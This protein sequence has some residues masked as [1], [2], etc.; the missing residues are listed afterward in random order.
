MDS[1]SD[2][3]K[4][5]Q[6]TADLRV[7]PASQQRGREQ[8][9]KQLMSLLGI[10]AA[11]GAGVRG[12]AGLRDMFQDS[13]EDTSP[14]AMR[15]NTIPLYTGGGVP[16]MPK[17][18]SAA[19]PGITDRVVKFLQKYIPTPQTTQP[20]LNDLGMPAAALA[21]GGG[22]YGGYKGLDSLLSSENKAHKQQQVDTAKED[23]KKTLSSQYQ[24]AMMAKNAGDDLGLCALADKY[25]AHSAANP[26]EKQAFLGSLIP[27]IPGVGPALAKSYETAVGGK[28]NYGAMN[29]A[30]NV[31]SLAALLG[32]G[33]ATYDW[34]KGKDKRTMIA[35]ALK[36]RQRQRQ[37]LSPAPML[38]IPE[39]ATED[40][41]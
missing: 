6:K 19:S 21:L 11:A 2:N 38:A 32:S 7:T 25:M 37:Q 15:P 40:G 26:S 27:Y 17:I 1:K 8:A 29:G 28:D 9:I 5:Q 10:G 34:A 39:G 24:Q 18:A 22:L 30:I 31:A 41:S 35:D 36:K 20:L 23:Y 14:T 12:V 16:G 13:P 4:A 3:S 33:K